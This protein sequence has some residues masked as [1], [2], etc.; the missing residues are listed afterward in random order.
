MIWLHVFWRRLLV[1]YF[2]FLL[3][4]LFERRKGAI[5]H[6]AITDD[7]NHELARL[8]R[9]ARHGQRLA[10]DLDEAWRT[11][12]ELEEARGRLPG[13]RPVGTA[14]PAEPPYLEAR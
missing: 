4:V 14:K 3:G 8:A 11:V 10:V 5:H 6:G 2:G 13:R 1:L 12:H 7:L 9:V